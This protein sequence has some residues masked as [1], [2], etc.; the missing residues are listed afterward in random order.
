M[1]FIDTPHLPWEPLLEGVFKKTVYR[2]DALEVLELRLEPGA[3]LKPHDMP[4]RVLFRILE[5]EGELDRAG[6]RHR[7]KPEDSVL[8]DPGTLRFWSNPSASPLRLLVTK[9]LGEPTRC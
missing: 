5:G 3:S 6:E 7:L 1:L 9:S 2:S 8:L 4:C